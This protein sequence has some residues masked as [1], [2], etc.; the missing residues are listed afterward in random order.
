MSYQTLNA[1]YLCGMLD[2]VPGLYFYLTE[3]WYTR[4]SW[5]GG[6]DVHGTWTRANGEELPYMKWTGTE[7]NGVGS[8]LCLVQGVLSDSPGMIDAPCDFEAC[9]FFCEL[10]T[11]H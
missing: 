5:I 4:F 3:S 9:S 6:T 2:C 11:V 8:E 7:P 1:F 10:Q